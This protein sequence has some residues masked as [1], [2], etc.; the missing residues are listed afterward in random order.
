MN[1]SKMDRETSYR[2][3]K[4]ALELIRD[5]DILDTW[6]ALYANGVMDMV[7]P[8]MKKEH[9]QI[10]YADD[11]TD[12]LDEIMSQY[13]GALIEDET[14]DNAFDL[15]CWKCNSI[16]QDTILEGEE[17]TRWLK[18]NIEGPKIKLDLENGWA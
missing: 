5:D 17:Y 14:L 10:A 1:M 8:N 15:I 16:I 4:N 7:N 13:G 3:A 11:V 6:I 9:C 18:N 2:I 12:L